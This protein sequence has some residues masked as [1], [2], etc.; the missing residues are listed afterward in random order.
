MEWD[1]LFIDDEENLEDKERSDSARTVK[2]RDVI[3]TN[4]LANTT[5]G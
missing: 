5:L 3:T 1:D 4:S 2:D